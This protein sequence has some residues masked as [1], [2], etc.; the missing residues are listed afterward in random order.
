M[1]VELSIYITRQYTGILIFRV[2]SIIY[3]FT[4]FR[5]TEIKKHDRL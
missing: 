3:I 1:T 5:F 2:K 4:S